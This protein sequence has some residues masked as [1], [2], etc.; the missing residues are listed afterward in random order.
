MLHREIERRVGGR[1]DD[2]ALMLLFG[3]LMVAHILKE[4][5][6]SL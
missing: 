5:V 2:M 6:R 4:M 3:L 1:G